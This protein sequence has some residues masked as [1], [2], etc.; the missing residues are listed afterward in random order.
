MEQLTWTTENRRVIDLK[1]ADYN[2]R[3]ISPKNAEDLHKSLKKFGLVE[4]PV[5]NKDGIL[6]AGHQRVK[7]MIDLGFGDDMIDVRVPNRQLTDEEAREYNLRSNLNQGEWDFLKLQEFDPII[8]EEAGFDNLD[9]IFDE[10]GFINDNK[11]ID[12]SKLGG[13][14]TESG[15]SHKHEVCPQCGYVL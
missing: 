3:K 5:I 11:E 1:P 7:A 10:N 4:I 6:L 15:S 14:S 12:P 13:A 8:L 9:K 2:P